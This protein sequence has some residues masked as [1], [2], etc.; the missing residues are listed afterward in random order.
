MSQNNKYEV[1]LKKARE[2]LNKA[3][4]YEEC[5]TNAGIRKMNSNKADWLSLVL[6][7]AERAIAVESTANSASDCEACPV[8]TETKQLVASKDTAIKDLQRINEDLAE[9]IKAL[10]LL[11][12]YK[13]E[14]HKALA[15]RAKIEYFKEVLRLMHDHCWLDG[16]VLVCSVE[17]LY[18]SLLEQ[19]KE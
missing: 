1:A 4:Y 13:V 6:S 18:R 17:Y 14:Q 12:D 16:T 15:Q 11:Y 9:R 8:V 7:L 2:E 5:G 19:I 10:Q 3:C